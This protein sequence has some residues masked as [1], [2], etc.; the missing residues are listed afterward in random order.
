MIIFGTPTM[1][2]H[3][4]QKDAIIYA[5]GTFKSC[6]KTFAQLYT[7]H[8]EVAK[9]VIPALF[10]LMT[11]RTSF[12]YSKLLLVLKDV[13]APSKCLKFSNGWN[14]SNCAFIFF[15]RVWTRFQTKAS[16]G[17]L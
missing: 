13:I 17:R 3:L 6:P 7:F 15:N 1:V 14:F 12:S 5:D 10:C 4:C 2:R 9:Y 16:D 8:V 11:E